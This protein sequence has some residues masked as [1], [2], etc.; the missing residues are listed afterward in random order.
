MPTMNSISGSTR[1]TI[2]DHLEWMFAIAPAA[3]PRVVLFS[4]LFGMVITSLILFSRPF[5]AI[6]FVISAIGT[7]LL[8]LMFYFPAWVMVQFFC[9]LRLSSDHKEMNWVIQDEAI[10]LFDKSHNRTWL[11]WKEIKKFRETKR[12]FLFFT[13]PGGSRLIPKRAFDEHCVDA[14]RDLAK[15]KINH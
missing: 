2:H 12:S 15:Q 1:I 14:I 7:S 8:F 13:K 10:E 3:I 9:Y 4:V 6:E 11:P 5:V